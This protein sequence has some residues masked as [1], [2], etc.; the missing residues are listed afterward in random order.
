[1]GDDKKPKRRSRALLDVQLPFFIPLWRRIA[2]FITVLIWFGLEVWGD[3]IMWAV[4]AGGIAIF[5][6][7][8]FFFAFNP[9]SDDD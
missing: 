6:G 2:T 1:M 4:L 7:H 8:Q 5:I 3:N 9:R